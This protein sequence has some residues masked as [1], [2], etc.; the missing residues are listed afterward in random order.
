MTRVAT[1]LGYALACIAVTVP[2]A[3]MLPDRSDLDA[4]AMLRDMHP[5]VMLAL[6]VTGAAIEELLCRGVLWWALRRLSLAAA[7]VGTSGAWVALHALSDPTH[8]LVALGPS[9]VLAHARE[10]HGLG[11]CVAAHG[12]RNT[13]AWVGL[14]AG[15]G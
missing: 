6:M 3:A 10:R 12:V 8:G 13:I 4:V 2:V 11:V 15:L 1:A 7:V 14:V 9:L 5:G